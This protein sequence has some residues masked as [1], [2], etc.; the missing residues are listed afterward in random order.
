MLLLTLSPMGREIQNL[1]GRLQPV[2]LT[3]QQVAETCLVFLDR[4]RGV[5]DEIAYLDETEP[6]VP[7]Q[8]SPEG[9]YVPQIVW[10]DQLLDPPCLRDEL[11]DYLQELVAG[12]GLIE[13]HEAV[14]VYNLEDPCG[15]IS[16][17]LDGISENRRDLAHMDLLDR[18]CAADLLQACSSPEPNPLRPFLGGVRLLALAALATASIAPVCAFAPA[19]ESFC[20]VAECR[21]VRQDKWLQKTA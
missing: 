21:E 13:D 19:R 10:R 1:T 3:Q 11:L 16:E 9:L 4:Q 15:L 6:W 7:W 5:I 12:F 8:G 14:L 20:E 18:A 17:V 2:A